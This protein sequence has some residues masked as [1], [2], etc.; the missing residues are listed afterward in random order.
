M[1]GQLLLRSKPFCVSFL[2]ATVVLFSG[3][4]SAQ[5]GRGKSSD[6]WLIQ[7]DKP[8]QEKLPQGIGGGEQRD[9][10]PS[11]PGSPRPGTERKKPPSPD[12]LMAKV[13]W[14]ASITIGEEVIQDWNLAP[15]DNMYF[16]KELARPNGFM[17]LETR[18]ALDH[19]SYD[20]KLMPAI[21]ISGVREVRFS[22]ATVDKL[23]EYV[24]NGGM[25]ICDSVYGSP[26]FYESALKVFDEMFP[27]S[28][29]RVLPGDHPLY[30]MLVD[31]DEVTYHCGGED[32]KKPFLE[33]LYIGSRVGVLVSRFG[34]GCGWHDIRAAAMS[35]P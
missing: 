15:N 23:R 10:I 24:L 27:E 21:M 3:F 9:L 20:P 30:H 2:C 16:H 35:G 33:G 32:N 5:D 12:Y 7:N 17:Y 19:F 11:V 29:F 28:R 1:T 13:V 18:I 6:D 34:I 22:A 26:W 8:K 25:I 31:I 14:G 4:A